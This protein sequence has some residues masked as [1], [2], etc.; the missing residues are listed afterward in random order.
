[1][2]DEERADIARIL[3]KT[4]ITG[5]GCCGP[6]LKDEQYQEADQLSVGPSE[7]MAADAILAAGYRKIA[8]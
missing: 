1:M 5:C 7:L 2:S 8:S 6:V 4:D 3:Q